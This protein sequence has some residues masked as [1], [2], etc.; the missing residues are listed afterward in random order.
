MKNNQFTKKAEKEEGSSENKIAKNDKIS[1]VSPY[2]AIST[3]NVNKILQSKD[4]VQ[5]DLKKKKKDST[6]HCLQ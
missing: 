5:M 4:N 1:S 2:I 3:L 6:V